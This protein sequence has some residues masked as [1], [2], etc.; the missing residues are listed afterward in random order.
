MVAGRPFFVSQY[1]RRGQETKAWKLARRAD[2]R[3]MVPTYRG[4]H[5]RDTTYF[6]Y[7]L[8][9][10]ELYDLEKDPH[11][12]N[13]RY[14]DA[15]SARLRQLERWLEELRRCKGPACREAEDAP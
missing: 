6:E 3:Y 14:E 12:L 8:G 10:R 2:G 1:E 5:T 11:Q 9:D 15:D 4:L 7:G 13:N